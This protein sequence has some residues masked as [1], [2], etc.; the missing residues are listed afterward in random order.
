M[1]GMPRRR[2]HV[3]PE[4]KA[5]KRLE[6]LSPGFAGED[7]ERI[8]REMLEK[9]E[10]CC[11][12]GGRSHLYV[13]E[14]QPGTG[15]TRIVQ[16]FFGAISARQPDPPF[17]PKEISAPSDQLLASRTLI[18]P[19]RIEFDAGARP[20]FAWIGISC[21]L[22]E[23]G[24]ARRAL[25]EAVK[26]FEVSQRAEVDRR[27]RP[28]RISVWSGL[29]LAVVV[30]LA[31][32]ILGLVGEGGLPVAI[33]GFVVA[34]LALVGIVEPLQSIRKEQAE[35]HRFREG[36]T[37]DLS[38]SVNDD[39]TD[40]RT[41][42]RKA[43]AVLGKGHLP[44]V[45]V[46]DDATWADPDTF[47]FVEEILTMPDEHVFAIATVRP[48]PFEEQLHDASKGGLGRLVQR[49]SSFTT[50]QSLEPL[51]DDAMAQIVL[52]RAPQTDL[53]VAE[54]MAAWAEGNPLVLVGG[55][56]EQPVVSDSL[57]DGV[58]RINNLAGVLDGLPKNYADVFEGHWKILDKPLKRLMA[59][60][61]LHGQ[62]V[63]PESLIEGYLGAFDASANPQA[64]V[65]EARNPR[66]WLRQVATE[67]LDQFT[68]PALFEVAREQ[69]RGILRRDKELGAR[70]RMVEDLLVR[71]SDPMSWS[72]LNSEARR[73]LLKV[74]VDAATERVDPEGIELPPETIV[75]RDDE[76][77][78][79]AIELA[80][81]TDRPKECTAAARYALT[82]LEW[83]KEPDLVDRART[84]GSSRLLEAGK[85]LESFRLLDDQLHFRVDRF[86]AES[87]ETLSTRTARAD[88][89]QALGRVPEAIGEYRAILASRLKVLEPVDPAVLS[90]RSHLAGAL[91]KL[92]R[93]TDALTE[94]E[95]VLAAR[96][97]AP[98][99]NQAD[100]LQTRTA[101][102][103]VRVSSGEVA[104]AIMELEAILVDREAM[105][106]EDDAG[107]DWTRSALA[108][109]LMRS[110]KVAQARS[111]LEV[112]LRARMRWKGPDHPATLNCRSNLADCTL[113]GGHP[114]EAFEAHSDILENRRR[115][116]GVHHPDTFV[117]QDSM[118]TCLLA[119]HQVDEAIKLYEQVLA[120]RT[121]FLGADHF[122][123]AKTRSGLASAY[124]AN[125]E[126][127]KAIKLCEENLAERQ[128][129]LDPDH[130][131][132][133]TI[134][135]E[136]A[137]AV[138][139]AGRASEAADLYEQLLIERE[140]IL[141]P[142]HPD[143]LT[144]RNALAG[145]LM[146]S[147]PARLDE[148]I[149]QLEH[150]VEDR[151]L[152]LG[153]NHPATQTSLR[154]LAD[155]LRRDGRGG[156]VPGVLDGS[157]RD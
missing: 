53:S 151:K 129:V 54:Q 33:I 63:Q 147:V 5:G 76:A 56:L 84:L 110:G 32:G 96:R 98:R 6:G 11:E 3:E 143:I 148:A 93:V 153:E 28:V 141:G 40:A 70:R 20:K 30:G 7:R 94:Y 145:A 91:R 61:S 138:A 125:R 46:I 111:Q 123:N 157:S 65:D 100:I 57:V 118:A 121:K 80:E 42:L 17:W 72:L 140:R 119:D 59:V 144:T 26:I 9:W 35:A 50:I 52:A 78:R 66:F 134:R 62:R 1:A 25:V 105:L 29:I 122:Q 103:G 154:N 69:K 115:V 74:H 23:S 45:V 149:V 71:R 79:S 108:G 87:P 49:T 150:V 136:L 44:A 36:T 92:G 109:A 139:A 128:Q 15:K 64:L 137:K 107:A 152:V 101:L 127:E 90:V 27:W 83:T 58:Y 113:A 37:V 41:R 8:V 97:A 68:D 85:A 99:P 112:V 47:A 88:A 67:R 146:D 13:L 117:T 89:L 116:L 135:G 132:L 114:V 21:K 155:A 95:T 102:A 24:A 43:I 31:V 131:V 51:T 14:G 16:E 82:A 75:P 133:L 2:V 86:G 10:A 39:S 55:L 22:D 4:S 124:V 34:L 81:L 73:V 156:E 130:P 142:D 60:A 126:A 77:A 19:H 12:K 104:E 106:G 38:D 18:I 120:D 48:D